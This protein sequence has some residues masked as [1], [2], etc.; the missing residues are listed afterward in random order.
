MSEASQNQFLKYFPM[1]YHGDESSNSERQNSIYKNKNGSEVRTTQRSVAMVAHSRS[2][3]TGL[4]TAI[5]VMS[6]KLKCRKRIG[7]NRN[8]CRLKH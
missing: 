5:D 4:L 3:A 6:E 2:S 1:S 7:L 8:Y